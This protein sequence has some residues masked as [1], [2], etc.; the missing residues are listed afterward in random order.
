M[1]KMKILLF[2]FTALFFLFG[3]AYFTTRD[4]FYKRGIGYHGKS[5]SILI[6]LELLTVLFAVAFSI[7][8]VN[9]IQSGQL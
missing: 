2:V 6:C 4:A 9:L 8:T 3:I 7:V 5:H 1:E